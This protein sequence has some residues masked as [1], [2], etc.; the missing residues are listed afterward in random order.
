MQQF[1]TSIQSSI[2][3]FDYLFFFCIFAELTI[4]ELHAKKLQISER[5]SIESASKTAV[6]ANKNRIAFY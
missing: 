3:G 2:E 4:V 1:K 6:V 5:H